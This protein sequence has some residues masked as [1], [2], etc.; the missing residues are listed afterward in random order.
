M[1]GKQDHTK[2]MI[3]K[4]IK[5]GYSVALYCVFLLLVNLPLH[6]H[7]GGDSISLGGDVRKDIVGFHKLKKV[8][9][10]ESFVQRINGIKLIK[11]EVYSTHIFQEANLYVSRVIKG[12]LD[13][14]Y[15]FNLLRDRNAASKFIL[16]PGDVISVVKF[17]SAR[18]KT[19][20]RSSKQYKVFFSRMVGGLI[21]L[22]APTNSDARKGVSPIR[23]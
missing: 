2:N 21:E 5:G 18:I 16:K 14:V 23:W 3:L 13:K 19:Y 8:E 20:A 9:S 7:R 22:H 6:A 1:E 4:L 15:V 17:D 10:L 12:S 11:Y